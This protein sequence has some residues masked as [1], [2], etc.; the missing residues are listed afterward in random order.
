MASIN[1]FRRRAPMNAPGS[2]AASHLTPSAQPSPGAAEHVSQIAASMCLKGASFDGPTGDLV[3]NGQFLDGVVNVRKLTVGPGGEVSG[4]IK[5]HILVVEGRLGGEILATQALLEKA[6]I[7]VGHLRYTGQM[8]MKPGARVVG[9]VSHEPTR[10]L[11]GPA[12]LTHAANSQSALSAPSFEP[13]ATSDA[14]TPTPAKA[15]A[16]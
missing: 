12:L 8:A 2:A 15:E 7:L 11:E 4:D 16:A 5:C 10:E 9:S 6:A 13:P 3:V 14:G 1:P